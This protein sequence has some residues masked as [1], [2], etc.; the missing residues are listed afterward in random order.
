M[1]LRTAV[2]FVAIQ[3]AYQL[4]L[5]TFMLLV[6]NCVGSWTVNTDVSYHK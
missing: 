4:R 3:R 5:T 6:G 2:A 1:W